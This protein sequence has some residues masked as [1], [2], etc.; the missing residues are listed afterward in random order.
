MNEIKNQKSFKIQFAD[1]SIWNDFKADL[2]NTLQENKIKFQYSEKT[3]TFFVLYKSDVIKIWVVW[4]D[5]SLLFLLQADKN[6]N[7]EQISVCKEIYDLLILF[8]GE[9]V[10]GNSPYDW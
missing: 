6:L 4:E 3:P 5:N 2:K 8:K 1:R 10:D 9:L 7:S